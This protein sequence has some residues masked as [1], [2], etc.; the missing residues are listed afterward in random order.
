MKYKNLLLATTLAF[1]SVMAPAVNLMN[2][3]PVFAEGENATNPVITINGKIDNANY[4]AYQLFKAE[5][6]GD[7]AADLDPN[8]PLT[9]IEWGADVDEEKFI[10][11]VNSVTGSNLASNATASDV[12]EALEGIS[13]TKTRQLA[14]LAFGTNGYITGTGTASVTDPS[15]AKKATITVPSKGYYLINETTNSSDLQFANTILKVVTKNREITTKDSTKPTSEKKVHENVKDTTDITVKNSSTDQ[16]GKVY[17]DTADASIGDDVD[18]VIYVTIPQGLSSYSDYVMT[19][20]D[21]MEQ[22]LTFNKDLKIYRATKTGDVITKG[23]ELTDQLNELD[24]TNTSGD[25]GFVYKF[26]AVAEIAKNLIAEGDTLIF[27]FSAELNSSAVI[28][29]TGNKNSSQLGWAGNRNEV[30]GGGHDEADTPWDNVLV[31]T[32]KLDGNKFDGNNEATKLE[33]AEFIL[34]AK[35]GEHSGLYAVITDGKISG[36]TDVKNSASKMTSSADGKFGVTGLDDGTYDL[37]EVK[38]PT[39]YNLLET[40]ITFTISADTSNGKDTVDTGTLTDEKR[41]QL[42]NLD[43]EIDDST[44]DGDIPTGTVGTNVP[45]HKGSTLPETG[46]MGTTMLY[47]VGGVL[48]A[49]AAVLMVTNKRMRKED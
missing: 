22:G 40:P 18:F 9:K 27:E 1:G 14:D 35:D 2:A 25:L 47:T 28:G 33:G 30:S 7:T 24:G 17:N 29:S 41:G 13:D 32:Y 37:I 42:V 43:I 45:N 8:V 31:F 44:S 36:W 16:N 20:K 46:G 39:G 26:D 23:T 12:A 48:V 49:G 21:V 34:Q 11:A 19:V 15:N 3:T 4:T 6:N 5:T 38:A 10:A